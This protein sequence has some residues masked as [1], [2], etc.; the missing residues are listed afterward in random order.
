MSRRHMFLGVVAAS[1]LL[2]SATGVAAQSP[3][4]MMGTE[5]FG[6]ACSALPAEGVGSGAEMAKLPV[7]SAASTN[8]LLSTLVTAVTAA[9]LVETLDTAENITVFAPVNDA[10]AALDPAT[11]EAALADPTGLLTQVL[12]YHVVGETITPENLAGAHTTLQGADLTVEGMGDAYTVNGTANIICGNIQTANATVYLLDGVL[13]PPAPGASMAPM[14]GAFGPA[15]SAIP[16]DG[17]GSLDGMAA[18]PVATAAS[19]NPLLSTLVTA[20]TAAGLVETLDTAED[21]TVFAPTNDAFA[22]L[23][24]ATLEAAL[25]DPTGLLT[26]VLTYHVVPGRITP[27][28][29]AGT[30]ATLQGSDLTV[31]GS[32]D[33][34]TVNGTA[35]VIC[36]NVQTANATVYILDGVLLPPMAPAE[37]T[38]P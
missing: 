14:A 1:S 28:T 37:S 27:E 13:L 4:A 29:L 19:S 8:P 7:A 18:A 2:L 21:I 24:P 6:P 30:H 32:G 16:A 12:T 34:F 35:A 22:A 33:A 20:V 10:F 31:E 5:P 38:A 11:L 23:D 3:D 36:G 17:A 9:G 26:T 25:A 15:C